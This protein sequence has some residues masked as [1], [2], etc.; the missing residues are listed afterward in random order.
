M[1]A[2]KRKVELSDS[3]KDGI[4]AS[5]L[6]RRLYSHALDEVEMSR[7]QIEA[8]KVVLAKLVPDLARQEMTGAD[9]GPVQFQRVTWEVVDPKA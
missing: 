3:W 6:L 7:T 8:A 2:R 5:C 4:R 1:A 9:G